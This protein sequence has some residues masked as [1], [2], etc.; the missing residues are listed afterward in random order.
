MSRNILSA[1]LFLILV[2]PVPRA[3]ALEPEDVLFYTPFEDTLDAVVARGS[4]RA[5]TAGPVK[6]ARGL[7]GRGLCIGQKGCAVFYETAGNI[8]PQ[9]GSISIWVQ[10]INWNQEDKLR[11]AFWLARGDATYGLIKSQSW[12]TY[13]TVN[14]GP[15]RRMTISVSWRETRIGHVRFEPG[16]W[17]HLCVTWGPGR[18]VLYLD[19]KP[20]AVRTEE[21]VLGSQWKKWFSIGE[22]AAS[23]AQPDTVVDDVVIFRRQLDKAEVKAL[24]EAGAAALQSAEGDPARL[25]LPSVR[26]RPLEVT[27]RG[28][29]SSGKILVGV[30]AGTV[31]DVPD[32]GLAAEL[33][34]RRPG[35][36]EPLRTE[37]AAGLPPGLRNV[38]FSIEGL[39]PGKY[40]VEVRLLSGGKVLAAEKAEYEKKP[41]PPW[42]GNK[43]GINSD[44]PPPWTPLKFEDGAVEMWGRR[45]EWR[46]GLF[47]SRITTQG[48][49]L[50]AEPVRLSMDGTDLA[51]GAQVRWAERGKDRAVLDAQ[52]RHGRLKVS[53]RTLIEF[54]GMMW[55][56]LRLDPEGKA[57]VGPLA[58][59]LPFH[60]E[61]ATLMM[62]YE[63]RSQW[64]GAVPEGGYKIW[65]LPAFW[66]GDEEGGVQWFAE[67]PKGWMAK[68]NPIRVVP[69]GNKRVLRI[70]MFQEKV[71]IEKPVK[72]SFGLMAT[73]VKP[74]PK[75]W[76]TWRFG[77]ED[78]LD[79]GNIRYWW[80]SWPQMMG[81]P[82]PNMNAVRRM[83]EERAK[84]KWKHVCAYC[85]L[86]GVSPH[87]PEFKYYGEEWRRVPSSRLDPN[88]P[89]NKRDFLYICAAAKSWQD[90]IV[91]HLAKAVEQCNFDALYYDVSS[92]VPCKNVH[93][94]CGYVHR[95]GML[96]PSHD[97]LALRAI[98]KRLYRFV[99]ARDPN[100][101]I[102]YHMSGRVMMPYQ[103]FC[104]AMLNG[105]NFTSQLKYDQPNYYR[106][107]RLD[108]FRAEYMGHN[109]GPGVLFLPELTRGLPNI[110]D[111]SV[112][113][114]GAEHLIGMVLLH[115]GQITTS[116]APAEPFRRL[117]RV[118]DE[119]GWDDSLEFHPYWKQNIA[120]PTPDEVKVSVFVKPN[121]S[122]AALICFNNTDEVIA[123]KIALDLKALGMKKARPATRELYHGAKT[124]LAGGSLAVEVPKRNFLFV[125]LE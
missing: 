1:F 115:D 47:P 87:S 33:V 43:I 110:K 20:M 73:P 48:H 56:E 83:A 53:T 30:D 71:T 66:L 25:I 54:D 68:A 105:E 78:L 57:E 122:K 70:E 14:A 32:G 42:L 10:P 15:S 12:N 11:H 41:D 95:D 34:L 2:A 75:P 8:L 79:E 7:R 28:L 45:Y 113:I 123:A 24:Y 58:L 117:W 82:V 46:K 62:P 29:P 100:F 39:P 18:A 5:E 102:C 69:S 98:T 91:W 111:E 94:G 49:D 109:L 106:L 72:I 4:G 60:A 55:I 44:V 13:F 103:S 85:N 19:G 118:L 90:F 77:S 119:F 6:F 17:R 120:V 3:E 40:E 36:R 86:S 64:A 52:S 31:V 80:A 59:E 21:V 104:D 93:H 88:A 23:A 107:L 61:R 124:A 67:S 63:Y 89:V 26:P 35:R 125:V 81:Y 101:F 84:S 51:A 50:L 121:G 22:K 92:I 9:R 96:R 65:F 112:L 74:R 114:P 116:H 16:K 108:Q 99:K 76:R 37:K 97:I 38:P 27:L